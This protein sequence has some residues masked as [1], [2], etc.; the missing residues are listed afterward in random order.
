MQDFKKKVLDPVGIQDINNVRYEPYQDPHALEIEDDM[1]ISEENEEKKEESENDESE[2][3]EEFIPEEIID[4]KVWGLNE[5][6]EEE[7]S[8]DSEEDE[9]DSEEEEEEG[10]EKEKESEENEDESM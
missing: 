8:E 3:E 6:G 9:E 5:E 2:E 1:D 10:E 7:E 4:P